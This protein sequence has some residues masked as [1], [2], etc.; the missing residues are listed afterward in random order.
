MDAK[1]LIKAGKLS[2]ARSQLVEEVKSS[3]TNLNS[4]T[5]LFQVQAYGGEWDKARRQ[6]EVITTQDAKRETGVQV[7]LN[8]IQAETERIEVFQH[9]RRPSFLP[10][11]PVYFEQYH[12]AWQKLTDQ[13][14][15]AAEPIFAEIGDRCAKISGTLNG[16]EFSGFS[17][18]DTRLACFLEAFVHERYVWLPVEMLRELT[19]PEPQTL[20]DLLWASALVTMHGGLTLNCFLPVLYPDSFRHE[21]DRLKLGRM[22][23]WT[24]L[25]SG[26]HQGF[27][28]HVYQVGDDDVAILE[29]RQ[30]VF[31]SVE[32]EKKDES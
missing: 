26:F 21:D 7:Y 19:L 31:N 22:T 24:D 4:R 13:D 28:Q 23:D 27:G 18:T 14:F 29:I 12:A 6:L 20:L 5:L 3:P 15:A 1:D 17:E 32:M 2:E 25:G 8:L 10:E 11:T 9:K 30:A 16:K